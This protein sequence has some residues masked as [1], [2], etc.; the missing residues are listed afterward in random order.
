[1]RGIP[2]AAAHVAQPTPHLAVPA[3]AAAAAAE[4]TV[5]PLRG[6]P[7]VLSAAWLLRGLLHWLLCG[8]LP[9][10]P[11]ACSRFLTLPL[12]HPIPSF[13]LYSCRRCC[14]QAMFHSMTRTLEV[15]HL[16]L[17]EEVQASTVQPGCRCC[18]R[19]SPQRQLQRSRSC[20]SAAT[21]Q[22]LV[23]RGRGVSTG[24]RG[25][26]FCVCLTADGCTGGSAGAAEGGCGAGRHP[27]HL[28]AL[29][30]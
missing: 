6:H 22:G 17:H 5:V 13:I 9:L 28:P 18:C 12:P 10:A 20:N 7:K 27:A 19:C 14:L 2:E 11:A 24:C 23:Q 4:P 1:V 30:H 15:P 3:V 16:N 29:L 26:G 21:W 8:L 25:P